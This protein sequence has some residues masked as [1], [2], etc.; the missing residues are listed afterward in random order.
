MKRTIINI[1]II[2]LAFSGCKKIL[3]PADENNRELSDIYDNAAFAEGLLLNG[4]VRLPISNYSFTDVATDDAVSNDPNNNYRLMATGKWSS[5][6][7]P[8][9]QWTGAFAAIQ[10]LNQILEQTDKVTWATTGQYTDAMFN[11]RS[12]G[13]AYGLRG[14]FMF[15]LLQ[16]HGGWSPDGKL[17]GV[18][19]LTSS[20]NAQSNFKLP[21]NTF[22]EC[23]QQIYK[24]LDSAASYLPLDFENVSAVPSKYAG[25]T[26]VADYNRVF[27]AYNRQ[28]MTARIVNA[29]RAKVSLL[30]ASPAYNQGTTVVWSKAADDAA[31][32]LDLNGGLAGI[33]ANGNYWYS[34]QNAGEINGVASGVNPAEILWRGNVGDGNNL[35]KD[36]YPPSLYGSGRVNPTQNLVDAFPMAN[37]YPIT[38]ASS[39]YDANNPYAGRD[40]R[41]ARY[42]VV[43]GSKMGP[44]GSTIS[45][46]VGG[47]N[48]GLN[49]IPTSTRTGYYMR[50]LLRED[51]NLNPA[52]TNT[53]RHYVPYIRYTEI[54][55][56]YAEA[57]NEAW[58]P[59]AKG[60]HA[61]SA[62]EIIAAIRKRAG[63]AQP[64]NYLAS[65]SSKE[66]MRALIQNERR[67]ELSFEGFRFWDIRRWQQNIAEP[68]KGVTITSTSF[69]VGPVEDRL[70]Q[71]FMHYGPLPYNEVLKE[72]LI[73]NK[74]W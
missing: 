59:D 13:E 4:Y 71:D 10:Y 26:T 32:V 18:P 29:I 51:V 12:K 5:I 66:D 8:M 42:I 31:K 67:L 49:A 22:E 70:Y 19:I 14:L 48:D 74:G 65:I 16:A 64:D 34:S 6:S 46:K 23:V 30:A 44:S 27:G 58:G 55:L 41:L 45:T 11:D 15:Y 54:Y 2:S 20:Q 43:N 52:N 33:A 50:K 37:G 35:E 68:A 62:R 24:D 1:L 17:L 40:P 47:T 61:Y 3:S 73:Q 57:A 21:R 39:G 28:R 63:I 53:Q 56:L 69:S 25:K 7:N 9:E 36:N 38:N 72:N 60:T